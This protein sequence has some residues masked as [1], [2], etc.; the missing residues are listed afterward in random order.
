M[1]M[2]MLPSKCQIVCEP[3]W[4]CPYNSSVL[5]VAFS[6]LIGAQ[7]QPE[8]NE[9]CEIQGI[10]DAQNLLKRKVGKI[11]SLPARSPAAW[12]LF[13]V[14]GVEGFQDPPLQAH[15]GESWQIEG[16]LM[17]KTLQELQKKLVTRSP[18]HLL[19]VQV[20]HSPAPCPP[21]LATSSLLRA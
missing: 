3:S 19:Q 5:P 8:R 1:C 10:I 11:I 16:Q 2:L 7:T 9:Y 13:G 6:L 4:T 21:K 12:S 17:Y 14:V 18:L 20:Q 15:P